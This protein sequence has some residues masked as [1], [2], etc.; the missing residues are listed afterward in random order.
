MEW[1]S[2][3]TFCFASCKSQKVNLLK[4]GEYTELLVLNCY[5]YKFCMILKLPISRRDNLYLK[6]K[7]LTDIRYFTRL[8]A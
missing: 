8:T 7:S 3:P 5:I 6:Y 1:K 2:S 4:V